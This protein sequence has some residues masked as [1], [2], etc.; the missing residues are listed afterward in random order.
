MRRVLSLCFLAAVVL[1]PGVQAQT[2][3][4]SASI[5][6]PLDMRLLV[7]T[8]DGSEPGYAALRSFLDHIG[9]PYHAVITK[10][11]EI[12]QLEIGSGTA[13]RG[14][15]YGVIL[16]TGD[17]VFLGSNGWTSNVSQEAWNR[18]DAYVRDYRVR[19]LVYYT[20]GN[21]RYGL[22]GAALPNQPTQISF[23][24]PAASPI[25]WYLQRS[26]PIPLQY[27]WVFGVAP[28]AGQ[29]E[30]TVP[31]LM[32]GDSVV[33]VLHRKPDGREYMALAVDNNP[34]LTH[35][36]LLNYGLFNW[37]TRG[38]FLGSRRLYLSPQSDDL[39]L[40]N[41][42]FDARPQCA[43]ANFVWNPQYE[44]PPECPTLRL[45]GADFLTLKSWQDAV[46][47][48]P[49]TGTFRTAIAYNGYG[50]TEEGGAPKKDELTKE[51]KDEAKHFYWVNHTYDHRNLDCYEVRNNRCVEAN[52]AQSRFQILENI[53]VAE[54]LK[55]PLDTASMVTPAI[56]GLTNQNFLRAASQ[57]GIRYLVSDTSRP[58]GQPATPNT[59]ILVP[60]H[61][62]LL[63]PRR[64]TNIFYNVTTAWT[65]VPG[66]EPDAY[67]YFYGPGGLFGTFFTERQTY[68]QIIDRESD[69]LRTYMLRYEL[70]PLM[71]HQTNHHDYAARLSLYSDVITAGINK[72]TRHTT[73]PILTLQQSEIGKLL[74]ERM[75][76]NESGARAVLMPGVGIQ[77]S[78]GKAAVVPLTGVCVGTCESY[79]G[80]RLS[81]LTMQAGQTRIIPI[82]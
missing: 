73:L 80:Q 5:P 45:S 49:Q 29:N 8:G 62:I 1:M 28:Y 68:G 3:N 17:L 41:H 47:R 30:T 52:Y 33:G 39:F 18:L 37:V 6:F 46:R 77:L 43:P 75:S 24:E 31:F 22:Q 9:I 74:E 25:F 64:P 66:S 65:G 70:Y 82:Q 34:L 38:V 56:S 59:G 10:T 12:P 54:N 58:E 71:F 20:W 48:N 53:K 79:G 57:L 2:S 63:V 11:S 72:V 51:A 7:L 60:G 81:R 26:N 23:V 42:L 32:A 27:A 35:S 78:V 15:Y 40:A 50:T 67:N 44:P 69:A 19:T 13:R 36:L 4:T 16:A 76:Y 14:L 21:T 61:N 55:L